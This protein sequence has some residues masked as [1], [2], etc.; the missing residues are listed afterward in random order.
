MGEHS[1]CWFCHEAA[2]FLLHQVCSYSGR[3]EGISAGLKRHP[4]NR[5][6]RSVQWH[7]STLITILNLCKTNSPLCQCEALS[8]NTP[9]NC[10]N[11]IKL[12]CMSFSCRSSHVSCLYSYYV[13]VLICHLRAVW[14]L[15]TVCSVVIWFCS[16]LLLF[17]YSPFNTPM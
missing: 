1:L 4:L 7:G 5:I 13:F 2:H 12:F 17:I 8:H 11:V 6:T 14:E 10:S 15:K 3:F 16:V 9:L